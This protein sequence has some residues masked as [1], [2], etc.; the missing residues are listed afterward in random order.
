MLDLGLGHK[1]ALLA[2]LL[3]AVALNAAVFGLAGQV[4]ALALADAVKPRYINSNIEQSH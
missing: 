3:K 1:T 4:L 2:V